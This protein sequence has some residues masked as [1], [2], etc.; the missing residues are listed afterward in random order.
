MSILILKL[1]P[2]FA[3]NTQSPLT[4]KIHK[5]NLNESINII[6]IC[7]DIIIELLSR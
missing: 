7:L 2:Q 4:L 1:C 6:L 3:Q 5:I